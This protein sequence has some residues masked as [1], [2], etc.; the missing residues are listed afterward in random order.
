MCL[1]FTI[2]KFHFS[3]FSDLPSKYKKCLFFLSQV[4][5]HYAQLEYIRSY[6]VD[7]YLSTFENNYAEN[8]SVKWLTQM[9]P[10]VKRFFIQLYT[11]IKEVMLAQF[12]FRRKFGL[13]LNC[14]QDFQK[15]NIISIQLKEICEINKGT[16][17]K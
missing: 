8:W 15:C 10:K 5:T 13:K 16:I 14:F 6:T 11:V 12:Y 3:H 17:H 1:P 4:L 7:I 9:M 2:S